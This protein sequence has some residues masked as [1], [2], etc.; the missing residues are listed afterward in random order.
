MKLQ[1]RL[2][3]LCAILAA[4]VGC[5]HAVQQDRGPATVVRIVGSDT[6]QPLLRMWAESYMRLHPDVSIYTDGGGSSRGFAALIEGNT[7]LAAGSRAMQAEEIKRL[8][9]N[10]GFLGQSILAAKDAL[11]IYLHPSNPV[12]D[13]SLG[14]LR[15][16]LSGEIHN[17]REVGGRDAPIDLISRQPNSG[18]YSFLR[19]HLLEGRP[20]GRAARTAPHTRSVIELVAA[21]ANALGYGGVAYGPDLIH[22]RIDGVEPIPENVRDGSYPLARYLYLFAAGPLEGRISDFVNWVLSDEAQRIVREVG[23]IPLWEVDPAG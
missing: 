3:L 5:T 1:A 20:Y 18:T 9:D 14:Q 12:R 6:M 23:Y 13:L 21:N 17:W 8:L 15:G 22:C 16:I 2:A 19:Q 10:R 11:S 7:D 4:A